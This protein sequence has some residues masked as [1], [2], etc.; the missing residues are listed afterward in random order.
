LFFAVYGSAVLEPVSV[1]LKE[2]M[3]KACGV[4][5]NLVWKEDCETAVSPRLARVTERNIGVVVP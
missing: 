5:V 3:A 2:D 4:R 1:L